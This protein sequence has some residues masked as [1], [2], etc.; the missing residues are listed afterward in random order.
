MKRGGRDRGIN[1][2]KIYLGWRGIYRFQE[3]QIKNISSN[4]LLKSGKEEAGRGYR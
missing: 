2:K 4:K 1:L 3:R